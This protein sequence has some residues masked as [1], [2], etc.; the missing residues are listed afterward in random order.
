MAHVPDLL[1]PSPGSRGLATQDA[2]A[3][4]GAT[5]RAWDLFLDAAAGADLAA[6]ARHHGWTG[7]QVLLIVG[8]WPQNRG[9]RDI[10]ADARAGRTGEVD[11]AAD[12]RA[13]HAAHAD[14]SPDDALAAVQ[15]GRDELAAWFATDEPAEV[16]LLPTRSL[17]GTLPVLTLLHATAYQLAVSALDLVACG[18][19]ASDELTRIGLT[20]LVDS[21]G[22]LAA[23]AGVSAS[24]T[25]VTPRRPG[26]DLDAEPLVV[27]AGAHDGDWRTE[28]L[29]AAPPGAPAIHADARTILD[30]TS[31]RASDVP[32]LYRSGD[33]A[34]TDLPGLL[35]LAPVISDVP[36]I[37]GGAALG[38]ALSFMN[39][40]GSLLGRL[41]FGRR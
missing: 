5:V 17:L 10:V 28:V 18:A 8:D 31:G 12:V 20:A 25:A 29:E 7:T 24:L 27:G 41:G 37:P 32:R 21:T 1:V 3:L 6:P 16:G 23:R 40:V 33:L 22:A 35:A 26:D 34:V 9:L 39:G 30:I 14:V 13:V 36:G 2:D 19:P 15:R 4:A 38:R 11:Q